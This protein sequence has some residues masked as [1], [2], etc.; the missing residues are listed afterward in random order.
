MFSLLKTDLAYHQ[1][2]LYLGASI[3]IPLTL[4][5]MGW[6]D[7]T[8]HRQLSLFAALFII[9]GGI[10]LLS[11]K[12]ESYHSHSIRF[13]E[14][15]PFKRRQIAL[16]RLLLFPAFWFLA[17]LPF[18]AMMF[19]QEILRSAAFVPFITINSLML[20]VNAMIHLVL[21][22]RYLRLPR[23]FQG[24]LSVSIALIITRLYLNVVLL[25]IPPDQI[26][27]NITR[28]VVINPYL[29]AA[30]RHGEWAMAVLALGL[31]STALSVYVYQHRSAYT[32]S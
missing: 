2:K 13:Y 32:D 1:F 17:E 24:F 12:L 16:I 21:D 27:G 31:I 19:T 7:L 30:F 18:V 15:I 29:R 6:G 11:I 20:L 22:I 3:L 4:A 25:M 8:S 14:A 26:K 5:F 23:W 9:T 28:F 10:V